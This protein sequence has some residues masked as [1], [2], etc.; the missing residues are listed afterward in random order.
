M[1]KLLIV[2]LKEHCQGYK[3]VRQ[4]DFR[5]AFKNHGV[6]AINAA[7]YEVPHYKFHQHR[8]YKQGNQAVAEQ[9]DK[10]NPTSI[11]S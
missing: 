6:G 2:W 4:N 9:A 10:A 1:I 7:K 3:L 11:K 5:Y 8:L